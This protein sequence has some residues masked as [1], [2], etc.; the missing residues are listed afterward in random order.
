M[1]NAHEHLC[2]LLVEDDPLIAL[3][4]EDVLASAGFECFL[5]HDT[6]TAEAFLDAHDI[7]AAILDYDLGDQNS[8]GIARRAHGSR[9]PYAFVTGRNS[10]DIID[11]APAPVAVH[12]K[13]VDYAE[14]A[15]ELAR[16]ESR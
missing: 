12:S 2:I 13:P 9:I 5:A 16:L 11:R 6:D 1:T 10:A 7:R 3:D 15:R 8:L 4:A 14:V